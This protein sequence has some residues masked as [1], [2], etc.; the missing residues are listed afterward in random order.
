MGEFNM[1]IIVAIVVVLVILV[2]LFYNQIVREENM[3]KNAFS[4]VDVILKKRYDVVPNL[5]EVVKGYASHEKELLEKVTECRMEGINAQNNNKAVEADNA[6]SKTLKSVLA[7]AENYPDLKASENFLNLQK[8]LLSLE[9]E[10]SAARRTY[11]AAAVEYNTTI[12]SFPTN[13]FAKVMGKKQ[14]ALFT[15]S[16]DAKISINVKL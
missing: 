15:I 14:K 1:L 7:I 11:N 13:I 8:V 6:F 5:V 16:N 12:E 10:L 2:T 4:T 9:D 3:V